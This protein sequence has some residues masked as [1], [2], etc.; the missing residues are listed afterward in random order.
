MI[1]GLTLVLVCGLAS[2]AQAG[3]WD[4]FSDRCLT[5]AEHVFPADL[6]GL[7]LTETQNGTETWAPADADWRLVRNA[8]G[9]TMGDFCAIIHA[10]LNNADTAQISE[11]VEAQIAAGDYRRIPNKTL[12]PYIR[13]QSTEWREP[14]I[15][16]HIQFLAASDD[17]SLSVHETDLES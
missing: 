14:R 7:T 5:R 4:T 12:F 13:L 8:P 17:P 1:K 15:E 6:D 11:W 16:V 10:P 9:G 3:V 2:G